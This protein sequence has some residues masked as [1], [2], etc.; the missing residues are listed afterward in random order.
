MCR[1]ME[2]LLEEGRIEGK[3]ETAINLLKKDKLTLEEIAECCKLTLEEVKKLQ[4]EIYED[5]SVEVSADTFY[6]KGNINHLEKIISNIEAGRAT[7][8]EHDLIEK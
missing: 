4:E 3:I 2:E 5:C 8:V 1:A 7:L 6:S